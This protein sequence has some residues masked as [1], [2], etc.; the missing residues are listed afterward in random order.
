LIIVAVVAV[1]AAFI[2]PKF[3]YAIERRA[4]T[5]IQ[6]FNSNTTKVN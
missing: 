4:E 1:I 6:N 5:T 3:D 2:L